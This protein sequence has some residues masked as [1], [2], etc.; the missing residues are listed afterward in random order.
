MKR[1]DGLF[2]L[3][4]ALPEKAR[5]RLHKPEFPG[6]SSIVGGRVTG[7]SLRAYMA[8]ELSTLESEYRR[9]RKEAG[10]K[11]IGRAKILG[12]SP[13]DSPESSKFPVLPVTEEG[14]SQRIAPRV[15]TRNAGLRKSILEWFGRFARA[16]SE[17]RARLVRSDEKRGKPPVFPFGTDLLR[18]VQGV[19]CEPRPDDFPIPLLT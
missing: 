6:M 2:R 18:R 16:Y 5:L 14:K 3:D 8:R 19:V 13:F 11:V 9:T 4:G 7:E 15:A 12:I 1:P 10:S 17:A